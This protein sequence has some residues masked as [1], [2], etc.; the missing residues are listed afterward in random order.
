MAEHTA[1]PWRQEADCIVAG[2]KN[3]PLGPGETLQHR[4]WYPGYLIC[5]T[6]S[7]TNARRIVACVNACVG[8]STDSIEKVLADGD[9]F[10]L[11]VVPK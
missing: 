3:D 10:C 4:E 8:I 6:V 11:I 7:R 5:E 1:E 9:A 2:H